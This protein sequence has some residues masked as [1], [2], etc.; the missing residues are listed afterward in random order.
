[1][2]SHTSHGPT[3][4]TPPAAAVEAYDLHKS[5]P[6]PGGGSIEIL[7]GISCVFPPGRMTALVGPS[8]SGKSTAL[9]CLA[10]LEPATSGRVVL[11]GR[12]LGRLSA[13]RIAELYRDHVGFVFQS[14]NLL[15]YLTVAENLTVSDTLASRRSD[16]ERLHGILEG[17]GLT[18]R[19]DA[20]AMTLS[21]GEQQRVALGRVL[22]RR[23]PVVFADEPTGALDSRSASFVLSQLR[24]MT[25]AGAA[26]VLVTHD[27]G[28]AS[29]AD[30][31]LVMRDGALVGHFRGAGPQ[32]LLAAMRTA[33]DAAQTT[34]VQGWTA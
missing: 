14:Y 24:G 11:A 10:G 6:V 29:L 3:A 4:P 21:G 27:L 26:V 18:A 32:E 22:Y 2:T 8:G 23:P 7:H 9:L 25:D 19:E 12:D 31:V 17:L 33:G 30:S 28:A 34:G 1:M 13:A 16:R 15:P 5:F 20:P